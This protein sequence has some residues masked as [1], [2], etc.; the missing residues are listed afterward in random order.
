MGVTVNIICY[1]SK[2]LSN[3]EYPL[4]I[5]VFK[6]KTRKYKSLGISLHPIYW[7]FEKNTPKKNC[8]NRELIEK[9]IAEKKKSYLE[10]ILMFRAMNRDYTA[11]TLVD[12]VE[13]SH[14][15][16]TVDEV[17]LEQIE[18]HRDENRLGNMKVIQELYKSL[19]K[20]NKDLNIYFVDIDT[21]WLE[22]YISFLNKRNLSANTIGI[23]LRT[24]R[25]I[26]NQA[27][28]ENNVSKEFYPFRN[29]K[30]KNFQ[31]ETVKRA[32]AKD[33]IGNLSEYQT[34]QQDKRFAIDIFLFS[35]IMG[36]I[37]FVDIALLTKENLIENRLIYVR[38]KTKKLVKLPLHSKAIELID[39]YREENN[40][41][42]FPILSSFHQT[43]QQKANRIHKVI[44]KVNKSLK[45]I[46]KE[47][48]LSVNLTTYVA[49]HSFAT[50][51]KK[52]GIPTAIISE[53][54]G[55]STEKITQVYLD[56]F[57]N[58]QIKEAMSNL[59]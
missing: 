2:T 40:L 53:T 29:L 37:N 49:R 25:A 4:M 47:L 23:R 16:K 38:R 57:D 56:S 7:D 6:D 48:C 31:R 28:K 9:I 35:Y 44:S 10:Q 15:I 22:R 50:I 3:G 30:F 34:N 19:K 17:F 58:A 24:L 12:K 39:S 1:K 11:S 26:Y 18:K 36:G 20:F 32:I 45:S 51:L 27:I 59:L 41:Y 33:D 43:E 5:R 13:K 46:G 14:Q 55:H 21:L 42:L 8:P 52:S 54:L